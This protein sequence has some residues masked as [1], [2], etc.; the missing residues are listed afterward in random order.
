[1]RLRPLMTRRRT[2]NDLQAASDARHSNQS[3]WKNA[4]PPRTDSLLT[5]P[6]LLIT[7]STYDA[8]VYIS[9]LG[10]VNLTAHRTDSFYSW[11]FTERAEGIIGPGR[12]G[13]QALPPCPAPAC[14]FHGHVEFYAW[15]PL[16][17]LDKC[18]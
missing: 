14:L 18:F 4:I 10:S 17:S 1:M 13:M 6:F 11:I 2:R 12:F 9:T 8:R 5:H 3:P 15:K 7:M 16:D